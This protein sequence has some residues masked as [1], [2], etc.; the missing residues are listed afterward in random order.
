MVASSEYRVADGRTVKLR[1]AGPGDVQAITRLYLELSPES[2]YRRFYTAQPAPPLVARFASL[3]KG[4]VCIVAAPPADPDGLAAEARYVPMGPGMA[5]LALTVQ[6]SYQGAGL[7]HL[8][9]D[10]LVQRARE[11]GFE[12]LRA[13][14]LLSN[15]PMLRLLQHYG[16]VLAAPIEEFSVA[17]LE[18][19]AVGGMPG[20]PEAGAGQRVLVERRG[21]FDDE[22]I[23]A[24]RS[25]GKQVRQ[26]TGP[27]REAGRACPLVTSGRCR[28]AE[29]ADLIVSLLPDGEPECAAV[30]AAHRQRWPHRLA[31]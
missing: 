19:S 24:L 15:T 8:M 6:D 1:S 5:E 7:G 25:A 30:L 23:A 14:V 3:G 9:L 31:E 13:V 20:W 26:C 21:W 22:Q 2:F 12:R 29:E 17:F 4:A 18:I 16:W 11:G 27:H 10:A 28:L